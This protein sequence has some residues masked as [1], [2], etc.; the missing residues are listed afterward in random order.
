MNEIDLKISQATKRNWSKL[1][2]T[3]ENSKLT[4][5]AN[6]TLSTKRIVP[7]E[8]ASKFDELRVES[9]LERLKSIESIEQIINSLIIKYL[10]DLELIKY[11]MG[12]Y[13]CHNKVI[14]SFIEPIK[15]NI[16]TIDFF[17]GNQF[18]GDILGFIYQTLLKEGTKNSQ[19]SYYTPKN[20]VKDIISG[21]DFN[22]KTVC[23]PCCGTGGF[24][25]IIAQ[26][27]GINPKNIYGF[28]I[29]V[30][31]IRILKTNMFAIFRDVEFEPNIYNIDFLL[32]EEKFTFDYIISNPPWGS[33]TQ[34]YE[35]VI[36]KIKSKESFSYFIIKS[37]TYLVPSGELIFLLPISFLNVKVHSDIREEISKI[38]IISEIAT[39]GKPFT[40]VLT[41]VVSVKI[42]KTNDITKTR[43]INQGKVYYIDSSRYIRNRDYVITLYN[44]KYAQ[45]INI[46]DEKGEY[47]LKNSIFALGVIT[48]DN[49]Q[50]ILLEKSSDV[51]LI[52]TGKEIEKYF[53]KSTSKYILYDRNSFQQ[54]AKDEY[55]RAEEKL[56]YKFI[57]KDLVF[58]YDNK[59]SLVLNSANIVIPK[60]I[61]YSIK[62]ICVLLN[63]KVMGFYFKNKI[64]QIKVLKSDLM[65]LPLPKLSY[66]QDIYLQELFDEIY[67]M[68]NDKKIQD[69]IYSIYGL[70]KNQIEI[71]EGDR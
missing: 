27:E 45:I 71:I 53:L 15:D 48:G 9:L 31:A 36:P 23:D 59:K 30:L 37:L 26:I 12:Q 66:E 55:Y 11:N 40:G 14:K 32:C 52:Y 10:I 58:A 7:S 35:K 63:S 49:N 16:F 18:D 13:D 17:F 22:N 28:D 54:V 69:Y 70:T 56:V 41:D 19:G 29:D 39:L 44:D 6:K 62:S 46:I 5:R 25:N 68:K 38:G 43:I 24:L 1:G 64:N 8:Y 57:S 50:Q 2:K 33:Q 65:A 34:A 4:K 67:I 60:K 42:S 61:D 21:I 3:L 51:E 47:S 20:L